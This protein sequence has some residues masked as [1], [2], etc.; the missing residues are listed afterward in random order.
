MTPQRST[1]SKP[2]VPGNGS[3]HHGSRRIVV[4]F[5]EATF[6]EIRERAVAAGQ[7]FGASVRELVEW[8]LMAE[9]EGA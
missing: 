2:A 7:S 6:G 8:G 9:G 1:P 5:D 3:L 4:S